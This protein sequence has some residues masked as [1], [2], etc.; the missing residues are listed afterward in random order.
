MS[1]V[2]L[3]T[4]PRQRV[5]FATYYAEKFNGENDDEARRFAQFAVSYL[6]GMGLPPFDAEGDREAAAIEAM[7]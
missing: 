6:R 1:T 5:V 7:P 2:K 3:P 4:D